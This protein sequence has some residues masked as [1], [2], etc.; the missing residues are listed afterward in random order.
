MSY[1]LPPG[2]RELGP[3]VRFATSGSP[4]WALSWKSSVE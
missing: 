2:F 1:S 4:N 3:G